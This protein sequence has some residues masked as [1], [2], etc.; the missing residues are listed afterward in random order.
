MRCYALTVKRIALI[1]LSAVSIIS[2]NGDELRIAR[3]DAKRVFDQYQH[4]KDLEK[5]IS[6]KRHTR[7]SEPESERLENHLKLKSRVD[8]FTA[9]IRGATAGTPERERLEQQLQI[10]TL[11]LQLDELRFTIES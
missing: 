10:A 6:A 7:L 1:F 11:E 5:E 3:F 4:T 8:D 2:A 9:R